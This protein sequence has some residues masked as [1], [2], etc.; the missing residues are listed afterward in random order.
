M[1]KRFAKRGEHEIYFFIFMIIMSGIVVLTFVNFKTNV[2]NAELLDQ[3]FLSRDL[4]MTITSVLAAPG[5]VQYIYN[6]VGI[7]KFGDLE[8]F[9]DNNLVSVDK[10]ER[11]VYATDSNFVNDLPA[12]P[13]IQPSQFIFANEGW[14]FSIKKVGEQKQRW[15]YPKV[16]SGPV[17][18]VVLDDLTVGKREAGD[19]V[20]TLFARNLQHKK[21]QEYDVYIG[22]E[23]VEGKKL[24]VFIPPTNAAKSRKF[25]SLIIDEIAAQKD[26]EHVAIHLSESEK[27]VEAKEAAVLIQMPTDFVVIGA[28]NAALQEYKK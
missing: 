23:F 1:K 27:L 28:L 17:N 19:S 14:L 22:V 20:L 6:G 26:V 8:Y 13:I 4:S 21:A 25:A 2:E 7:E 15:R 12:I 3:L 18:V 10:T 5:D 9:F 24:E 16:Q 11:Y